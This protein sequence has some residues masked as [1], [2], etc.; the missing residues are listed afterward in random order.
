MNKDLNYYY[1]TCDFIF[2]DDKE[3][4]QHIDVS[5]YGYNLDSTN[6]RNINNKYQNISSK[7]FINKEYLQN[8]KAK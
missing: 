2:V 4:M 6:R 1:K 8:H 7:T 3:K 5:D